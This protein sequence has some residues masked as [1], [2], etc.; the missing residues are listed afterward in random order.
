[1]KI[2][3]LQQDLY[4]ALQTVARSTGVRSSLPVLSNILFQTEAGKLILSATNLEIGIIKKINAEIAEEGDITVPAKTLLE[5]ISSLSGSKIDIETSGD[6][7]KISTS[8]FNAIINGISA[9]EFPAIPVSSESQ[10]LIS[11][12]IL[13]QVLPEISFAAATDEGRPILTG[14]LTEIKKN[15]LELVATDGFRLAH[16]TAKLDEKGDITFKALIPKRT[17]E[18][19]VRLISEELQGSEEEKIEITTSENQNQI[20]FKIGQTIISSRLIE[21]NFPAWEKIIPT[22][23][24]NGKSFINRTIIERPELL[25]A[26]KLASIFAKD[27]ASLVKMQSKSGK[28]TLISETK[29]LGSQETHLDAKVEGEEITI[30]FNSHFLM[31][32]LSACSSTQV[33]IEFTSNTLPVLIKPVGEESLEYVVMP[34]MYS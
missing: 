19:V 15:T 26:V 30:A 28:I 1:M 24:E 27:A 12:S 23:G 31:D 16:K 34:V 9:A 5:I 7:L 8:N 20:I 3:I 14:I 32:A 22:Q 10:V 4:P 29:E 25:K 6:Q 33:T 13:K 2:S 18:E 17:F 21:G 11:G